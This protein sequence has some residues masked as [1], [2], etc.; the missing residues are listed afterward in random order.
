MA[1]GR[2]ITIEGLDGAGKTTQAAW[3]AEALSDRGLAVRLLR[4]PG[5]VEVS[6]RVRALVMDPALTVSPRAEALLYAAARAQLVEELL[7]PLLADGTWVVLDRFVDSSLA[8]QG[9]GRGL[10][11]DSV[12]AVNAFA[13]GGLSP[14]RTVLL[15]VDVETGRA[16]QGARGS[17]PDRLERE[18]GEFFAAVARAYDEIAAADPERVRVVEAGGA[19]EAVRAAVLDAV[20]DLV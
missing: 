19:A 4:E 12:A 8:Y 11:V 20:S 6:E 18:G 14:D 15:R 10:G 13:T 3:L 1:R 9:G 5:G 16:R 2:L 17:E 7:E